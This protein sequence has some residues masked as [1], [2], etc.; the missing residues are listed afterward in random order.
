MEVGATQARTQASKKLLAAIDIGSN[1][2]HLMIAQVSQGAL[3]I[4]RSYRERVQLAAGLTAD[5]LLDKAAIS[6]G[7]TCLTRMGQ[8]LTEH[9][10]DIVRV[11]ATHS[12]RIASNRN[13]FIAEAESALGHKIEVISGTEEARVIF[14]GVAHSLTLN[15]D[16]LVVDIG[17]GSTELAIGKGFSPEFTASC[18]MGCVS[19][20]DRFFSAGLDSKAFASAQDMATQQ[21]E[22]FLPKLKKLSWQQAYATSG[23]AKALQRLAVFVGAQVGEGQAAAITRKQLRELRDRL[24]TKGLKAFEAADLGQ[25]RLPLMPGGVAIMLAICEA[26]DIEALHYRDVALREGVLY[27]LDEEM[28]QPDIVARTRKSIHARYQVDVDHAQRVAATC[29]WILNN[30]LSSRKLAELQEYSHLLQEA[31]QLHEVGLQISAGGL[32]KHSHYILHHSDLPGLSQEEQLILAQLVLRY[33]KRLNF[34]ELPGFAHLDKKQFA[35]LTIVLRLA[36]IFNMSRKSVDLTGIELKIAPKLIQC[37][38]QRRVYQANTLLE[39]DLSRERRYLAEE[40]VELEI[41]T[42]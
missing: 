22:A 27:E 24:L 36:I 28:R 12:L 38:I 6:R 15:V 40:G 32:Q 29:H 11:V 4:I 30:A 13:E 10:P 7:I 2:I 5:G 23:T 33:R 41:E 34:G 1:S 19:F 20:R 35:L 42:C 16:T 31:A 9:N 26:L 3:Q 18:A 14:L 17:G 39:L 8:V 25:D 21:L 37:R